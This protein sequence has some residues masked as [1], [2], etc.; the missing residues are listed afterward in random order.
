MRPVQA[1]SSAFL[2]A[3][4]F[5]LSA[6]G[7]SSGLD[8]GGSSTTIGTPSVP[9][10]TTATAKT[11]TIC[12]GADA[13]KNAII[14]F[15]DAHEGDTIEFCE[16]K[17]DFTNGLVMTGKKGITIKGQGKDKTYL[18]FAQSSDQDGFNL[19]KMTGITVQ[20]LTIYDAPGNGLRIFRS[21]YVTVRDVKVRWSTSDPATP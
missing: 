9:G 1:L 8:R 5:G 21:D 13:Q 2:A 15:F 20:G 4:A 17:F 7:N 14:A 19:N 18:R 10:G 11:Y 6:C 3:L 12:P 16:G